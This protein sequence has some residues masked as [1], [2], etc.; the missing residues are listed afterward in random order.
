MW[1]F[2]V[3]S[4]IFSLESIFEFLLNN[5]AN[6]IMT[7]KLKLFGND[8]ISQILPLALSASEIKCF[9]VLSVEE[10]KKQPKNEPERLKGEWFDHYY[11]PPFP[12]NNT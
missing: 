10:S 2:H 3:Y 9:V 5:I 8:T 1:L 4:K 11:P 12:M 7:N 6:I